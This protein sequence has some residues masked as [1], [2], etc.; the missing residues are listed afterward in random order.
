M[1]LVSHHCGNLVSGGGVAAENA[2]VTIVSDLHV[3][4]H[5]KC[6]GTTD[7][8]KIDVGMDS[9]DKTHTQSTS[10]IYYPGDNNGQAGT[11]CFFF[12]SSFV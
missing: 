6:R 10:S 9:I 4:G 8:Q 3:M 2:S 7:D 12:V 11:S 1:I 5:L